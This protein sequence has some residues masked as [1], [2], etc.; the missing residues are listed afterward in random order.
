M[1]SQYNYHEAGKENRDMPVWKKVILEI[2]FFIQA[3]FFVTVFIFIII[4]ITLISFVSVHLGGLIDS[5]S[6]KKGRE[7]SH[8]SSTHVIP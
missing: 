8:D 5:G 2:F 6:C 7:K 4:I 3:S 1:I